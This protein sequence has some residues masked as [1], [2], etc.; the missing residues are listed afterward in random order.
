MGG[1]QTKNTPLECM[2]QNFKKGFNGDY[3]VKLTSNKFK[4]L[5]EVDWSAF[6]V[7]RPLEGSL[8][9][10]VVNEVYRVIVGKPGHPEQFPCIDRWQDAV[11]S[12]PKWLRPCLEKTCRIMAAR[13]A[14]ASKCREKAKEPV[15]VRNMRP[16]CRSI[17]L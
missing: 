3:G 6:G 1:D 8:D 5:C 10:T 15:L 13:V 2:V 16:L 11:L 12:W 14:T 9:K 4:A 7:G 17:H